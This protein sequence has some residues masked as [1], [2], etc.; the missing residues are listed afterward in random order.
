LGPE[1]RDVAPELR[2][3]LSDFYRE[4]FGRHLECLRASGLSCA[5]NAE[6]FRKACDRLLVDIERVC[7]RSDFPAVA[8]RLLL[9]FDS[10]TRLS[11]SDRRLGH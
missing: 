2:R 8:E 10:L 4:E 3:A 9:S 5:G 1:T 11:E 6:A 7:C